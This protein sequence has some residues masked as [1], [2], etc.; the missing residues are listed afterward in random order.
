MRYLYRRIR[1][2]ERRDTSNDR[3]GCTEFSSRHI[4]QS[5]LRLQKHDLEIQGR[6]TRERQSEYRVLQH[7]LL[8]LPLSQNRATSPSARHTHGWAF[9]IS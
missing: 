9:F 8:Q 4:R 6:S 3:L 1:R 2:A 7:V 5:Y